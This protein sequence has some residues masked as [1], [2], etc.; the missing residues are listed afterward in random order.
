MKRNTQISCRHIFFLIFSVFLILKIKCVDLCLFVA[1]EHQLCGDGLLFTEW[2]K[3]C[4]Q[5][6][7]NKFVFGIVHNM[8]QKI[9]ALEPP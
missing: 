2:Q 8:V 7:F 4:K 9:I 5:K 3:L 6:I 1:E